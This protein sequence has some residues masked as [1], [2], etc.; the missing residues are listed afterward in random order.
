MKKLLS[1]WKREQIRVLLSPETS[2]LSKAKFI[3]I[4]FAW[5]GALLPVSHKLT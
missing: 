3:I 5:F 4:H 2:L 1:L